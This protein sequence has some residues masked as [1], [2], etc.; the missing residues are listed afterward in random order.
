MQAEGG[1][2]PQAPRSAL[3]GRAPRGRTGA[4]QQPAARPAAAP[5][6]CGGAGPPAGARAR[7]PAALRSTRGRDRIAPRR[8][9]PCRRHAGLLPSGAAGMRRGARGCRSR[10]PSRGSRRAAAAADGLP[11]PTAAIP[12]PPRDEGRAPP[13]AHA[14]G[15]PARSHPPGRSHPRAPR[16]RGPARPSQPAQRRGRS[17]RPGERARGRR[18]VGRPHREALPPGPRTRRPPRSAA[19]PS[20]YLRGGSARLRAAARRYHRLGRGG[21]LR[22]RGRRRRRGGRRT[23]GPSGTFSAVRGASGRRHLVPPASHGERGPPQTGQQPI[24]RRGPSGPCPGGGP[25]RRSRRRHLRSG[26]RRALW[27]PLAAGGGSA[28]ARGGSPGSQ[29][30]AA[31]TR[32]VLRGRQRGAILGAGRAASHPQAADPLIPRSGSL[33]ASQPCGFSSRC[34][35]RVGSQPLRAP[36][37]G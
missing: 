3:R 14:G 32:G 22:R 36:F 18:G 31:P 13:P 35:T 25:A 16:G 19:R 23:G 21:R 30:R 28:A 37:P 6:T 27:R 5:L 4:T 10:P 33:G 1:A 2:A 7:V 26:R 29:R 24:W 20:R 11:D 15:S 34:A 12:P 8:A 9:V 17:P